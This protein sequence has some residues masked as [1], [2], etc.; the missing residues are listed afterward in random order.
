MERRALLEIKDFSALY[1]Y[2]SLCIPPS[3]VG[4][5]TGEV[6]SGAVCH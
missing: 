2:G 6:K 1:A 3:R 5:T 4:K